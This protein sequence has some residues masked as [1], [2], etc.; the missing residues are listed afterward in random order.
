MDKDVSDVSLLPL[1]KPPDLSELGFYKC[2]KVPL[3]HVLKNPD[4][5]LE[6]LNNTAIKAN[7]I[8]VHTLQFMK[9]YLIHFYEENGSLPIIDKEFVNSC[10]KILCVEKSS[11]RPILS[12]HSRIIF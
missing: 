2:V 3:T 7:K 12:K 8:I 1:K 9:L 11:G 10:M 6:K 4:V 5:N